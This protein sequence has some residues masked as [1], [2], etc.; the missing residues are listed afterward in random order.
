MAP[1]ARALL[2]VAIAIPLVTAG[3]HNPSSPEVECAAVVIPAIVV[4]VREAGTGRF[5]VAV[6][7]AQTGAQVDSLRPYHSGTGDVF[8]ASPFFLQAVGPPGIYHVELSHAGY[9]PFIADGVRVTAGTCGP[10]T[11]TLRADLVPAST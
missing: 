3:C 10:N 5:L 8:T 2:Q 4:E 6:G 9:R 7:T 11:V 1:H